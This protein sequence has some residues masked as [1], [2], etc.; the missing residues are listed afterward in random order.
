MSGVRCD[1]A[2]T[3][4]GCVVTVQIALIV[5]VLLGFSGIRM[6]LSSA[7]SSI[8]TTTCWFCCL[9]VC[10]FEGGGG[11]RGCLFVCLFVCLYVCFSL[12]R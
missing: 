9:L 5:L 7:S 6:Y 1:V 3:T 4:V 12:R 8:A 2:L 11:G 10:L